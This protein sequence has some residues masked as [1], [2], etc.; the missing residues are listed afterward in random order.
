MHA[1]GTWTCITMYKQGHVFP[2]VV[3]SYLGTYDELAIM[4]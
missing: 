1:A 4:D 3:T 2:T